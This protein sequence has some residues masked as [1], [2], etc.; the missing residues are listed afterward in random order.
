MMVN[1][2]RSLE[3]KTDLLL[4]RLFFFWTK[5]KSE[6]KK[7][8]FFFSLEFHHCYQQSDRPNKHKSVTTTIVIR[9]LSPRWPRKPRII[10][11]ETVLSR[12]SYQAL[13]PHL[14][15]QSQLH[16][17]TQTIPIQFQHSSNLII[18]ESTCIYLCNHAEIETPT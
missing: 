15:T 4:T 8:F 6:L 2:K 12:P 9:Y 18:V 7:F 3:I 5:R 17:I 11:D 1:Q 13:L 10:E 16:L 14:S